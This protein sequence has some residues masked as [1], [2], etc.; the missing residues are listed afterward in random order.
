MPKPRTLY[1]V[2]E[3]ERTADPAAVKAAYRRLAR[4]LHPD[5]TLG[6]SREMRAQKEKRFKEV[7]AAYTVLSDS[8]SR[9]RYDRGLEEANRTSAGKAHIFG[10]RFDDFVNRMTEEGVNKSNVENLMDDFF[11]I[12]RE[13]KRDVE[14]KAEQKTEKQENLLGLIED[15]FGI[16]AMKK[17]PEKKS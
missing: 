7:A 3:I 13:F 17:T 6:E 11:A 2:L 16:G 9:A 15:L 12:A 8:S 14:A 4:E 5:R 1:D 10:Q